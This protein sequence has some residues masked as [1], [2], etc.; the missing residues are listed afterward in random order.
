MQ[1][2]TP[3]EQVRGA[4]TV[5]G[6]DRRLA[7]IVVLV[8]AITA[9][10][11]LPAI[12][13]RRVAGA[14]VA[15]AF[16]PPPKVGDCVL[17]PFPSEAQSADW[18]PE[19]P[20]T[21]IR[22]GSCEGAI[23]GEVVGLRDTDSSEAGNADRFRPRAPCFRETAAFAGLERSGRSTTVPGAPSDGPVAWLPTVG[24]IGYL[25]VPST[26]ERNAGRSWAACLAVPTP[27]QPAYQGSLRDAFTIGMF[28][29]QFGLCWAEADLD[30]IP[31]LVG[32]A[33]PH[34]AE[35][36][37]TG[38]IRNRSVVSR[39]EIDASCLDIAGRI[40]R[41]DD[42]TRGG[43][44]IIVT[45]PVRRD[46]ASSPDSPMSVGCFVTTAGTA[47]L[48]GTVIGLGDRPVPLGG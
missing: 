17:P 46:G 42:P 26:Q 6:M 45:D 22:F 21:A 25:V 28:P 39:A 24:F 1:F 18:P 5:A 44:L 35:L 32:C 7:G 34:P 3:A 14:A 33:E 4:V 23:V 36:L 40:M 15:M 30:V 19:I 43:A 29:D 27:D 37:A 12:D 16:P 47:P 11:V 20:V 31:E 13:G 48:A 38:W 10:A 8:V 9:V 41:A 2:P